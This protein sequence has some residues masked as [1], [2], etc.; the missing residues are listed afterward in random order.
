MVLFSAITAIDS[1]K[2]NQFTRCDTTNGAPLQPTQNVKLSNSGMNAI[3]T[4]GR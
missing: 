2:S 4:S 1:Q 3:F